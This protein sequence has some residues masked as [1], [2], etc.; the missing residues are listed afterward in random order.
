MGGATIVEQLHGGYTD[1]L[2]LCM[3][4]QAQAKSASSCSRKTN[5]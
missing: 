2:N 5:T 4:A 1:K 3:L